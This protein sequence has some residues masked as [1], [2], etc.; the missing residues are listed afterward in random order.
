VCKECR[1]VTVTFLK[2]KEN[3]TCTW[4]WEAGTLCTY[5]CSVARCTIIIVF[6][7]KIIPRYNVCTIITLWRVT[8]SF[9]IT[10]QYRDL[11]AVLYFVRHGI[12]INMFQMQYDLPFNKI[13]IT[14]PVN[15][16]KICNLFK[17]NDIALNAFTSYLCYTCIF[18][19]K[20]P[21]CCSCKQ[22]DNFT[23]FLKQ[24]TKTGFIL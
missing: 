5:E 9:Q 8:C 21:H 15:N 24:N 16:F 23:I 6:I 22:F 4:P 17:R 7:Q 1:L 3:N 19:K 14:V 18:N 2:D 10:T 12:K 13:I 20:I 11:L